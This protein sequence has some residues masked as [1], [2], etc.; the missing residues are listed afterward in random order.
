MTESTDLHTPY[1]GSSPPFAIGLSRLDP[2][3]WLDID[4]HYGSYIAEKRRLTS[5]RFD[6]VFVA[7]TGTEE[8]QREAA[9]LIRA[10]IRD[11]GIGVPATG[12]INPDDDMLP[13]LHRAALQVQEDLV[14]MRKGTSG[15]R[16]AAASLCFPSSWNLNE[17]F[18]RPMH[19]IHAPVP[20]FQ[21]GSRNAGLIERMFDN[22]RPDMPVMRWN[23]SVYGDD[24]LF[25][26]EGHEVG[27]FGSGPVAD[28]VYLRLERQ[29][30]SKLPASGD[31]LF[32]IRTY[33]DPLERLERHPD[34]TTLAAAIADQ[35]RALPPA[36]RAYKGLARE[37]DRLLARLDLIGGNKK[38]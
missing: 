10:H 26:P 5:A 30:L 15:W 20:G 22:L 17:K 38:A 14:L 32:T 13:I 6:D 35:V 7:E 36:E 25:H 28:N 12:S 18:G 11:C 8:A 3:T 27:R 31:I 37:K 9:E 33:V 34:G 2:D 16:L 4:N 23:W 19:E 21:E 1:D 24:R 29:T